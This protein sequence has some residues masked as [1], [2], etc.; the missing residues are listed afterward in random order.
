[1]MRIKTP[2]G[3]SYLIQKMREAR[4]ESAKKGWKTRRRRYGKDGRRG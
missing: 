1:M 3:K 2:Y 4:S